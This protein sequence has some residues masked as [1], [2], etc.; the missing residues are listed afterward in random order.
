MESLSATNRYL[1]LLKT[2]YSVTLF[3]VKLLEIIVPAGLEANRLHVGR[4]CMASSSET[5]SLERAL[6]VVGRTTP[7]QRHLAHGGI[8]DVP[9]WTALADCCAECPR[10]LG[11]AVME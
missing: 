3:W 11:A 2:K 8:G 9:H 10:Q 5:A 6:R 1:H 4:W 7:Q